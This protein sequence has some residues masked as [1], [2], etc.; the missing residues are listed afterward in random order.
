VIAYL[1]IFLLGVFVV[2]MFLTAFD[3]GVEA[4]FAL[5]SVF[6]GTLFL[7]L[8]AVALV[9]IRSWDQGV[10]AGRLLD[11]VRSRLG[12]RALPTLAWFL[13]GCLAVVGLYAA[14]GLTGV[15]E[16]DAGIS[17]LDDQA[18]LFGGFF[19]GIV[20]EILLSRS[21]DRRDQRMGLDV[22]GPYPV[23]S[24]MAV[25]TGLTLTR[26]ERGIA[27]FLFLLTLA[28]FAVPLVLILAGQEIHITLMFA[29]FLPFVV[30]Q[31]YSRKVIRAHARTADGDA[32]SPSVSSGD[33][34]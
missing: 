10:Q 16:P 15:L 31:V 2:W 11:P 29:S 32:G 5:S 25:T 17:G 12:R 27:T 30:W 1:G 4:G 26:R 9:Q 22:R 28:S 18:F 21:S 7:G 6:I 8:L 3:E 13:G 20:L 33:A 23:D 24:K 14:L 19:G 34:G